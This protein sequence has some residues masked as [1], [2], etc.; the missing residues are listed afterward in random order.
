MLEEVLGDARRAEERLVRP[1]R[2]AILRVR[3]VGEEHTDD[4]ERAVRVLRERGVPVVVL[5]DEHGA[6]P[7]VPCHPLGPCERRDGVVFVADDQDGLERAGG[8]GSVEALDGARR[9]GVAP[10]PRIVELGPEHLG[11]DERGGD[12]LVG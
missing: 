7:E 6:A 4:R 12:D 8:E 1:A 10:E 5:L 9:P 3:P 2:L 11:V